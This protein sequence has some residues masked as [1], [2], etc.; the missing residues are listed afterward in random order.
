MLPESVGMIPMSYV[1]QF[2]PNDVLDCV[3]GLFNQCCAD[4]NV[5]LTGTTT[6]PS[7][8]FSHANTAWDRRL[9]PLT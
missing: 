7:A 8:H 3:N 1:T 4:Q 9:E 6:P 5:A 2:M